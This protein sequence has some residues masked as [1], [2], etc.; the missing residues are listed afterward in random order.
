VSQVTQVR[1]ADGLRPLPAPRDG[2]AGLLVDGEGALTVLSVLGSE[3]HHVMVVDDGTLTFGLLVDEVMGVQHV[4]D[5]GVS[6][7][8]A[9]QDRAVVAGV[10]ADDGSLVLLID[11][12]V[13]RGRLVG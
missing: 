5:A 8:P 3:G 11:V 6:P 12:A 13:L 10:I 1:L 7:P 9:G 4:D 2:V